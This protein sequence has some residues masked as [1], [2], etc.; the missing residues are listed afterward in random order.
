MYLAKVAM[1]IVAKHMPPDTDGVRIAELTED[2]YKT[3]LWSH[4]PLTDFWQIG[5]GISRRLSESGM[6]TMGDIAVMSLTNEGFL[7]SLF[8]IN[9]ELIIDH[10][11]GIEPC[12]IAK[13]KT[14]TPTNH[15]LNNGQVL[16]KPYAYK[17]ARLV[18]KEMTD[19]LV[20]DLVDKGI[21]TNSI[22]MYIGYDKL[23]AH[24]APIP[25]RSTSTTTG[26]RYQAMQRGLLPSEPIPVPR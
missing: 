14:Y 23:D 22:S 24:K 10:A 26:A 25:A 7:Y 16:P 2:S 1:D 20:L 12:T 11:W 13:I 3:I 17:V 18:V 4:T 6:N 19:L 5:P 8:G 21:A 15:S 9:A